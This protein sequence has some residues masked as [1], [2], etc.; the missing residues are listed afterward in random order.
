MF[1]SIKKTMN[2][3]CNLKNNHSNG[4]L[5]YF[6][7]NI[8]CLSGDYNKKVEIYSINKN[9]WDDLPEMLK[10]RSNSNA[11]ILNN[12]ENKYILNL[13]GYN[14]RIFKYYRIFKYK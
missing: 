10:E 13:F 14:K 9:E 3:L 1:D 6:E 8:I 7:N 12:K 4:N 5:L 11:C 2:K